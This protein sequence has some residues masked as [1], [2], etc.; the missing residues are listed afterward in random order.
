MEALPRVLLVPVLV[1]EFVRCVPLLPT[2]VELE[3]TLDERMVW[4]E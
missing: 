2:R 4:E 3:L 1:L